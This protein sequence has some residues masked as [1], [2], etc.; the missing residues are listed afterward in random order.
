MPVNG[1]IGVDYYANDKHTFGILFN[2]NTQMID[3]EYISTSRTNIYSQL[4]PTRIDSTLD[5]SNTITNHSYNA[6][7]NLNYRFTDTIGNELSVDLDKGYFTAT[8]TSMQPNRYIN[9][10]TGEVTAKRF[11]Q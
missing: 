7:V 1:K 10:N 8:S 11:Y 3:K 9:G 6:N 5:A 4:S 2:G